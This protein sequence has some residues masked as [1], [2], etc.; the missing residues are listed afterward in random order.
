M[1]ISVASPDGFPVN[2][3]FQECNFRSSYSNLGMSG[4]VVSR[5][6]GIYI[7]IERER[8]SWMQSMELPSSCV[9]NLFVYTTNGWS[10]SSFITLRNRT[11]IPHVC[12]IVMIVIAVA[13][14]VL[15]IR[16]QVSV[17]AAAHFEKCTFEIEGDC[18][19]DPTVGNS[20]LSLEE[21][22]AYFIESN[23]DIHDC[24]NTSFTITQHSYSGTIYACK[25]WPCFKRALTTRCA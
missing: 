17:L 16:Q 25:F 4:F 7:Y 21:E 24:P 22:E 5:A 13:A 6:I 10:C 9:S 12:I 8:K 11:R 18:P 14:A 1:R 2:I 19:T 23:F 15:K 20:L 3:S